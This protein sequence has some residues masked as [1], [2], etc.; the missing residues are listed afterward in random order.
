MMDRGYW[1]TVA[2][3]LI[4]GG[5]VSLIISDR[6][7]QER[8]KFSAIGAGEIMPMC[9]FKRGEDIVALQCALTIKDGKPVWS[10]AE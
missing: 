9:G 5:I 10:K 1:L 4:A 6:I 8:A 2:A 7:T 3:I